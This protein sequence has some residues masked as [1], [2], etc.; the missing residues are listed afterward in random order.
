[1][2]Q[3]HLLMLLITVTGFFGGG[4]I[5]MFGNQLVQTKKNIST[6]KILM[7]F[8]FLLFISSLIMSASIMQ[9][10]LSN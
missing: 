10:I 8:G 6:G 2:M 4:L 3:G 5:S 1:M 9:N 7:V